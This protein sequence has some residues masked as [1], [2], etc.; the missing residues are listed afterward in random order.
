[1]APATNHKEPAASAISQKTAGFFFARRFTGKDAPASQPVFFAQ[2]QHE[3]SRHG[4][5][6]GCGRRETHHISGGYS[7]T[8]CDECFHGFHS[9]C[10]ESSSCHCP[11]QEERDEVFPPPEDYEEPTYITGTPQ[12][13][14]RRRKL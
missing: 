2:A 8:V 4:N 12:I 10:S 13:F 7:V 3:I 11:C 9:Q 1:M 6:R 14:H 5:S